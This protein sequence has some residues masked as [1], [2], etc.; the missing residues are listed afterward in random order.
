MEAQGLYHRL[1]GQLHG[2]LRVDVL[3]VGEQ[4]AL[5][6]KAVQ[7]LPGLLQ[8]LDGILGQPLGQRLRHLRG[9]GPLLPHSGQQSIAHF[10]QYM[11]RAAVHVGGQILAQCSKGMYHC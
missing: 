3:V 9:H 1:A 8:L 7:F 10:V 2:L 11:D 5:V 6:L 4:Q